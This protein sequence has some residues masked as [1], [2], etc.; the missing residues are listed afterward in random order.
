MASQSAQKIDAT[1]AVELGKADLYTPVC[2]DCMRS[3]KCHACGCSSCRGCGGSG[4][5]Y[6]TSMKG[7]RTTRNA[8]GCY[9]VTGGT[10]GPAVYSQAELRS[11][12]GQ[13][14]CKECY[15][16]NAPLYKCYKC[17]DRKMGLDAASAMGYTTCFV[18]CVHH[19]VVNREMCTDCKR[20]SDEHDEKWAGN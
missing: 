16:S 14:I 7:T 9:M 2:L 5:R 6:V 3:G 1:Q 13:H 19:G 17:T 20:A 10:S 4:Y 18:F 12:F 15:V 11:K 8:D